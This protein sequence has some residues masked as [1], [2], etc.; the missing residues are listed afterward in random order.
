MYNA[1]RK[2]NLYV[3]GEKFKLSRSKLDLFLNCPRCFYM[4]RRLGINIP[5]SY[6]LSLNV[7][8]DGLLKKEFDQYRALGQRHPLCELHDIDAIPFAHEMIDAWRNSLS[9]G[10]TFDVNNITITGGVD[11]VWVTPDGVLHIVDYKA[12][13]KKEEVTLDADWQIGYKRQMEIYQWLFRKNGFEVSNTGYFVYCNGN[14]ANEV[15]G[16]RLEFNTKVIPY[17]GDDSWVENVVNEA[18][19]CLNSD[20]LPQSGEDCNY[21]QY[22]EAVKGVA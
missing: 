11:D 8:V 1:V 14:V 22:I 12:T 9:Q 16:D 13:A 15:F 17:I 18:I 6:P 19:L 2:R 5:P 10:I 7:A 21:C 4:D 3:P 20:V